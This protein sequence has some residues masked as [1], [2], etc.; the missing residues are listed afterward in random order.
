MKSLEDN[1]YASLES[2]ETT[3]LEQR[4]KETEDAFRNPNL[5]IE[6]IREIQLKQ[7]ETIAELKLKLNEQSHVKDKLIEMNEF[8][9]NLSF[10]TKSFGLLRL[11]A[12]SSNEYFQE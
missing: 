12:Y 9:P 1:L 11:N 7:E 4:L 5:L 6:S 10:S 2:F 3:S 8:K